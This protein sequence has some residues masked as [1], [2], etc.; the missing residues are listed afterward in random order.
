MD[1]WELLEC[2]L[3]LKH[4]QVLEGFLFLAIS[5]PLLCFCRLIQVEC[6]SIG[7]G[8]PKRYR[9]ALI[10]S[11]RG[12]LLKDRNRTNKIPPLLK[13][14]AARTWGLPPLRALQLKLLR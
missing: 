1:S 9:T 5:S 8:R 6:H 10:K 7:R 2:V 12:V 14:E 3:L 13:E 4:R 11:H